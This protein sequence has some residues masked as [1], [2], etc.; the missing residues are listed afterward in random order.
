[1][2][3]IVRSLLSLT[4]VVLFSAH[5]RAVTCYALTDANHFLT[6]DSGTPGTV[7]DTTLLNL[8]GYNLVGMAMRITTQTTSAANPGVGSIWALGSNG[9]NYKLFIVSPSSNTPTAI[10]GVLAPMTSAAGSVG[11]SAWGF[12]FNPATDRFQAVGVNFNFTIDPNTL[13]AVRDSDVHTVGSMFP[14]FSGAAFTTSSFGGQSQFYI[15]NTGENHNLCTSTN[16]VSGGLISEAGAANWGGAGSF[17]QPDGLAMSGGTTLLAGS[18]GKFYSVN[19]STGVAS[20]LGSFPAATQ[21]RSVVIVPTSFPPTLPVTVTVRGKKRVVSKKPVFVIRGSAS[22]EAGVSQV[23]VKVGKAGF[24]NAAG[25]TSWRFKARLK[26]GV[27]VVKVQA[28][29]SNGAT[30][31]IAVVR[32]I[33]K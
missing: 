4:A 17:S 26:R 23:Q 16:I 29:G 11:D 7:T 8:G 25:T 13:T 6:F 2:K 22:C 27:N 18:D 32:I 30:S 9:T 1:M 19:R 31:S 5:A 10:S 21:I 12:A 33:R 20:L 14:A 24:R 3:A 15:V 28:T